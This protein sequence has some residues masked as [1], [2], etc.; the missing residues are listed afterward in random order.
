MGCRVLEPVRRLL[1]CGPPNLAQ[2]KES[3]S[4]AP[5]GTPIEVSA[6]VAI[7]RV[8]RIVIRCHLTRV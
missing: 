6:I 8:T 2:G 4:D 7:T 1:G 3:M 5:C